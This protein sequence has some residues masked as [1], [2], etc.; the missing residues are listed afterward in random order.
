VAAATPPPPLAHAIAQLAGSAAVAHAVKHCPHGALVPIS[1]ITA[2]VISAAVPAEVT[3]ITSA[4]VHTG[5]PEDDAG[6]GAA[7]AVVVAVVA[8]SVA[9][10]AP[11]P[12]PEVCNNS[13]DDAN[14][15]RAGLGLSYTSVTVSGSVCAR[16]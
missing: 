16:S 7:M 11:L 4:I 2:D 12:E 6:V 13:V 9:A 1:A 14:I 5:P 8:A 3:P 10:A 15:R